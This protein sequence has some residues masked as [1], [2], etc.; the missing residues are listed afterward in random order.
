MAALFRPIM[1]AIV[2]SAISIGNRGSQVLEA[3]SSN[4]LPPAVVLPTS[5]TAS[6]PSVNQ[7]TPIVPANGLND[8]AFTCSGPTYGFFHDTEISSCVEATRIIA[9]GRDRIRFV[10]RNTPEVTADTYPLPW[11]WMDRRSR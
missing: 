9:S 3:S 7:S 10:E 1:L 6:F 11:R 4:L 5:I 8:Y 2:A